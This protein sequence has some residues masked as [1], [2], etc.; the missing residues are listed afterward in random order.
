MGWTFSIKN[1][2]PCPKYNFSVIVVFGVQMLT[3]LHVVPNPHNMKGFEGSPGIRNNWVGL[4]ITIGTVFLNS[5]IAR[6]ILDHTPSSH[7][8]CT[9]MPE[10]KFEI[11]SSLSLDEKLNDDNTEP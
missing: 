7:I 2:R 1:N 8:E 3:H 4:Y 11:I 9:I 6:H 10:I 5:S